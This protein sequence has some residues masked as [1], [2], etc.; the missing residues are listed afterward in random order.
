MTKIS[1]KKQ[2]LTLPAG[3]QGIKKIQTK[4]TSEPA[5][6]EE[7]LAQ[8]GFSLKTYK[9][10]DQAGGTII[11]LSPNEVL[12]DVG[13]KSFAQIAQRELENI[14]DLINSLKVGDKISGTVI[15]TENDMGYLVISVRSLGYEKKWDL[16]EEK[17]KESQEIEVKGLE[18]AK[19][20]LLVEYAGL[21]AYIPA[22][23]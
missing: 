14:R 15:S 8:T 17:L 2:E 16:L 5:T 19:G 3:R 11:S 20:G 23:S 1:N 21:R 22:S 12:I 6:M 10:G 18:L 13:G 7:L 9:K 4:I